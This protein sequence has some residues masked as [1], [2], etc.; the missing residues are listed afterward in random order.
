MDVDR[1][2]VD[3][4][5]SATHNQLP[6]MATIR[7]AITAA[8]EWLWNNYWRAQWNILEKRDKSILETLVAYKTMQHKKIGEK[9]WSRL[10][11]EN[12]SYATPQVPAP[13]CNYQ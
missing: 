9:D 1:I 13:L 4:R 12:I 10:L 5:H 8:E 11:Q 7:I 2:L 3:L 6:P